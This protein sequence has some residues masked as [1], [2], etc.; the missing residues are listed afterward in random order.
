MQYLFV[1]NEVPMET[2]LQSR[3]FSSYNHLDM[4]CKTDNNWQNLV[5]VTVVSSAPYNDLPQVVMFRASETWTC[6][7]TPRAIHEVSTPARIMWS[8]NDIRCLQVNAD[9]ELLPSTFLKKGLIVPPGAS[10]HNI[11]FLGGSSM[12][13][14]VTESAAISFLI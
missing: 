14:W 9:V 8:W 12:A 5:E 11:G 4:F 13:K 7:N 3:V 1:V 10:G 6:T 2:R